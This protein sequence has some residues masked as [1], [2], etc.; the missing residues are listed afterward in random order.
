[1]R[2]I[3]LEAVQLLMEQLPDSPFFIKDRSLR[4]VVVNSAM[5]RLCGARSVAAMRGRRAADFFDGPRA[6]HYE[7]LDRRV[8]ASR[9]PVTHKLESMDSRDID[10]TWLMYSRTPI[11]DAGEAVGVAAVSRELRPSERVRRTYERVAGTMDHVRAGFDRP[12]G[13]AAIART[14]G[15]SV[16][17]LER[18]FV[19][20]LELTPREV[21]TM[22]RI[23]R[24]LELLAV[25]LPVARVAQE[26]GFADHS[27]FTRLFR[28][29]VG[30]TPL[31]Y[32][33]ST[34]A[35]GGGLA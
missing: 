23:E 26:C 27:A 21:H 6:R 33:Q 30:R 35:I 15:V 5:A 29:V 9:R 10:A 3:P 16:S 8:L 19:R 20:V 18:D 25:G 31:E 4:Y 14:H 32:A 28:R 7:A 1:M 11:I 12:L 17:Q 13:L 24:A 34:R 22:A 2:A